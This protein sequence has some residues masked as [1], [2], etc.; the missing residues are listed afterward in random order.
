MEHMLDA[1]AHSLIIERCRGAYLHD[2]RGGLQAIAGA[3]ELLAR[4]A[5]SGEHNPDV[6]EKASAIAKRAL[7]NHEN[8][9]LEMVKQMAGEDGGTASVE[10][11]TLID[12]ILRFLRNDIACKQLEVRFNRTD[13]TVVRAEKSRLHLILLGL[14]ALRIDDCPAGAEL[15]IRV[16]RSGGNALI[17][18]GSAIMGSA[19]MSSAITAPS[20]VEHLSRQRRELVLEMARQWFSAHGGSAELHENA[21]RSD[22]QL[23]YPLSPEPATPK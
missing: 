11:G 12:D 2:M 6:V 23:S 4:L 14:T 21:S 20:P 13:N 19:I 10:L 22:L 7:A 5:R 17:E 16:D 1:A 15:S 18:M 3:F 9:M 8:S